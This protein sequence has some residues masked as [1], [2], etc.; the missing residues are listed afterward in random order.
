[1][2][3]TVGEHMQPVKGISNFILGWSLLLFG[4]LAS[5]GITQ[6]EN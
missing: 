5:R 4:R 6:L 3:F 1:M 2:N